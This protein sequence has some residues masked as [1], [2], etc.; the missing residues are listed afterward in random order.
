MRVESIACRVRCPVRLRLEY[1]YLMLG[2]TMGTSMKRS[3]EKG[4]HTANQGGHCITLESL[5]SSTLSVASSVGGS[6]FGT[7]RFP[8]Q[9]RSRLVCPLWCRGGW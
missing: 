6:V 2:C 8:S 3:G 7:L 5:G 9:T 4:D 1:M